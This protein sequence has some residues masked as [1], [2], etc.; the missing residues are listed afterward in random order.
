MSKIKISFEITDNWDIVGFRNTIKALLS[1]EENY[2]IY[3]ISNHDSSAAIYK[4]G[5]LLNLDDDHVI[6]ANFTEDKLQKI[7]DNNID[8]HLD[9]I[10]GFADNVDT[11][12]DALGVYVDTM[13]DN[14]YN[15]PKYVIS[16]D[17]AIDF[18]KQERE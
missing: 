2:D 10:S 6:V 1:D 7:R 8:I 12:T 18:V 9:N 4:A 15:T 13:W 3:I 11:L 16:L 5:T 17:T 14:Y